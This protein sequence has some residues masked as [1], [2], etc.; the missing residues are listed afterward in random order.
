M[1]L[2]PGRL[3]WPLVYNL[4]SS[5]HDMME[6][7]RRVSGTRVAIYS[8]NYFGGRRLVYTN[9]AEYPGVLTVALIK[10]T[11]Y[12]TLAHPTEGK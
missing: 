2:L 11:V 8:G 5:V 7:L 10:H 12:W 1:H 4:L 3:Y 6:M 9:P